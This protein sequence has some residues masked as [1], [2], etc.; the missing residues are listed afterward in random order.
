MAFDKAFITST[1]T[2]ATEEQVEKALKEVEADTTGLR[3][4]RDQILGESK[5]YKEKL[6]KLTT[7]YGAKESDF[8]CRQSGIRNHHRLQ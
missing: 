1:F 6:E 4:N 8:H 3:V 5:G 7:E 2:G